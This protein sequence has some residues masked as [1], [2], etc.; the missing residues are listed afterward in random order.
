MLLGRKKRQVLRLSALD[1]GSGID[2]VR[3]LT[4]RSVER[5]QGAAGAQL[6]PTGFLVNSFDHRLVAMRQPVL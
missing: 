4:R 3:P 1:V 5:E 6:Q 2:D